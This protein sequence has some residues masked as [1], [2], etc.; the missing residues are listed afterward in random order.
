MT[1]KSRFAPSP[2][3]LLHIGNARSAALNWAYIKNKG[4]EFILRIDDTDSERSKEEHEIQ[5]KKDLNWLGINWEKTFNQSDRK[6][7]Y[8]KHILFLKEKKRLYPCF[9][10]Q[11]ELALKRKSLL[12]SGKPPIYDRSSLN[13]TFDE[14]NKRINAGITPHWRFKLEDKVIQWNDIIKGQ[15]SFESKNLSDP[16]LIREDGSLLYHLPSVIDD[17]EEKITDVI[18]GEDH[19]SNTAFH[20]QIFESLNSTIPN[21]GH[22]PFLT[23]E[24]G[25]GFAKRLGSLS[26]EKLRNDGFENIT[27][28]NYLLSIGTSENLSK[29]IEIDKLINFFNIKNL[30]TSSPKF[31]F[32]S[33]KHLNKDI[34]QKYSFTD[35][36]DKFKLLGIKDIDNNFWDL[37]KNNIS[38]FKDFEEWLDIVNSSN[39]YNNEDSNFLNIAAKL[40]PEE[41]FNIKTWDKW[42][43][44]INKKTGEKGKNLYMPLRIALTGKKEGPELKYLIPLLSSKY[45]LKKFQNNI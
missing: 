36:K 38:Y 39:S 29:E 27:L 43:S 44:L 35:V 40:L 26:V 41:P 14:I 13:L 21:F 22:H 11:E 10:S 23:D 9:E 4:G 15:V 24:E 32:E 17:I 16:I 18:R 42:T 31:S 37:I 28:L 3:G 12:T 20:I 30:S 2:T 45:I 1:Y 8:D 25:K 7:L 19:I 34:L 5:I 33:L 6:K